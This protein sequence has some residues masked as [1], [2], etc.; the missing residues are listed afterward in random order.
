MLNKIIASGVVISWIAASAALSSGS[1]PQVLHDVLKREF[2]GQTVDRRAL[3]D[4]Q[5][6]TDMHRWQAGLLKLDD[7]WLPVETLSEDQLNKEYLEKRLEF[8]NKPNMHLIL[9]HW[10]VRNDLSEQARAHYFGVLAANPDHLE[11]RKYL[12]Y[13][14]VA[15]QWVEQAVLASGQLA[16]QQSLAQL[17]AWVPE[18]QEIVSGLQSSNAKRMTQSMLE[19]DRLDIDQ[20][21]PALEFFAGNIDDDLA[22]P[23]IRKISAVK[24]PAACQALVRIS[25]MHSSPAVRQQTSDA[26]RTYSVHYFVPDLLR[27][28]ETQAQVSNRLLIHNN[29]NIGLETV[30]TNELQNRKQARRA[31]RLVNVVAKFT[32]SSSVSLN[33]KTS[34]E[35]TLISTHTRNH[36]PQPIDIG[37][38]SGVSKVNL[39]GSSSSATYVPMNVQLTAARNLHEHGKQQERAVAQ[40]NRGVQEKASNICSLLRA[41]TD[42]E[43]GDDAE[44]WWS[45]WRESNERYE[46]NKPTSYAYTQQRQQIAIASHASSS[47]SR[48]NAHTYDYGRR[49][50]GYSC[51]VAGTLVQTA[52]GLKPVETI[53]IGDFVLSQDVETAQLALK[54]VLLTTIRPPKDTFEVV[55]PYQTIEATG[56]HNWW[57]SGEGWVMTRN[58]LPNMQLHTATGTLTVA[59][60]N[61]NPQEQ[62]TFNLVVDGFHT[63][64]VGPQRVLSYDNTLLEPTLRKVPGFDALAEASR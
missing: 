24:S 2:E 52:S 50:M 58:L 5:T 48:E 59:E 62:R 41:T 16:V 11:A 23:L 6:A 33:T 57:V 36:V 1:E 12:G 17:E 61:H 46:S 21:L 8:C 53:Q 27:M 10:C 56:G 19:L 47:L 43:L 38:V 13:V 7:T 49:T 14:W 9:A 25:L 39:G 20:A 32:S 15:G 60:L 3:L 37:R 42:A 4:S 30:V 29:G 40:R 63:Y 64:F 35:V 45:W 55:T 54:P 18:V 28:L 34:G 51:L 31:Q 26:I 44:S 22:R